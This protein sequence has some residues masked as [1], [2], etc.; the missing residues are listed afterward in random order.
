M[1]II[2][3]P[4]KELPGTIELPE[5]LTLPQ[6]VEYTEATRAAVNTGAWAHIQSMLPAQRK[7]TGEWKIEGLPKDYDFENKPFKP[8][9]PLLKLLSWLHTEIN[10]LIVG[11]ETIPNA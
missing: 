8:A 4:V 1:K 6:I 9:V 2:T 7:L 10:K 11:E 3:S 5:F